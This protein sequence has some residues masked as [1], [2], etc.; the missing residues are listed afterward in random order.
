MLAS[1]ETEMNPT[2]PSSYSSIPLF[3]KL[4]PMN[5]N[6]N[7]QIIL[8]SSASVASFL[9]IYYFSYLD[10]TEFFVR[11]GILPNNLSWMIYTG[12]GL[13]LSIILLLIFTPLRPKYYEIQTILDEKPIILATAQ[14]QIDSFEFAK[15]QEIIENYLE[16]RHAFYLKYDVEDLLEMLSFAQKNEMIKKRYDFLAKLLNEGKKFEVK[17]EYDK[18]SQLIMYYQSEIH[19]QF[20]NEIREL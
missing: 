5:K 2:N 20:L 4:S 7:I 1:S 10:F 12:I 3:H 15:T 18:F 6:L 8:F 16:R 19:P 11:S 17:K 13:I 9:F 14:D